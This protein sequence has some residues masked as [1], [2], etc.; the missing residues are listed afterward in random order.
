MIREAQQHDIR[1]STHV[2]RLITDDADDDDDDADDRWDASSEVMI[3]LIVRLTTQ[4][5]WDVPGQQDDAR[6]CLA[7]ALTAAR[8]GATVANYTEVRKLTKTSDGIVAGARV[9]DVMTGMS[10]SLLLDLVHFCLFVTVTATMLLYLAW[11]GAVLCAWCDLNYMLR[12]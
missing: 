9:K 6:M 4:H 11:L 2:G 1:P 3:M 12:D 5:C 7:I 8:L 10:R